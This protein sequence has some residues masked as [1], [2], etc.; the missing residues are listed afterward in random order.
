M[1][2]LRIYGENPHEGKFCD[3]NVVSQ[4]VPNKGDVWTRKDRVY[5]VEGVSHY[6]YDG[7]TLVRV[8]LRYD[9]DGASMD[10]IHRMREIG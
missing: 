4:V 2:Y 1:P 9:E 6:Q 5:A 10:L 7:G 3:D 8:L